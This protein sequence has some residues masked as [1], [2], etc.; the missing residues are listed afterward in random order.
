MV[1]V[2][3]TCR[4]ARLDGMAA[5]LAGV[6]GASAAAACAVTLLAASLLPLGPAALALLLAGVAALARAAMA[7]RQ[8]GG[9]T[10]DVLGATAVLAEC[11][12]LSSL[13]G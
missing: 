10:G 7:R 9:H 13:A 11:L 5:A 1:V 2:L 3:M 12:V 8:V 4:P 6:P